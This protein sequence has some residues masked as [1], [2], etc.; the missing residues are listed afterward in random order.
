MTGDPFGMAEIAD[1]SAEPGNTVTGGN[2]SLLPSKSGSDQQKDSS[3]NRVTAGDRRVAWTAKELLSMDLPEPTWGVPGL[4]PAGVTLLAGPPKIGKSWMGLGISV[5]VATGGKA[6]GKVEVDPGDVLYLALEDT[7]RRL[8]SRLRMM[9]PRD[10]PGP[11]TLTLAIE[12]PPL[13]QGGDERIAAWLDQHPNAR[14]VVVDVFGRLR[15]TVPANPSYQLD[16]ESVA[17][18]KA[19]ADRYGVAIVLVHHTRKQEAEDFV[20]AVSGTA[21]LGA[22]ADAVLVLRR[23][24][25][26]AD[27]VLHIT[28]RDLEEAT[29]ALTFARHLGTWELLEGSV[30]Q[31]T[32]ADTR[33]K[34]V[35]Y[36]S[37]NEGVTPKQ[38]ADATGLDHGL[39][40]VTVR[41]MFE[42]GQLNT[43]DKGHYFPVSLLPEP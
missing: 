13:P 25:G 27:A 2:T 4:I 22:A 40:K 5:A 15:G 33:Q 19:L 7:A 29:H 11:E 6:L 42:E 37:E 14:L 24:R 28:G 36:I 31:Y 41:R 34:I 10:D 38:I 23:V 39:V 1:Q 3:G 17:R 20:D 12:C 8:K 16:Y 26:K 35:S 30:D 21:G 9:L 43:D 32:H 18:F